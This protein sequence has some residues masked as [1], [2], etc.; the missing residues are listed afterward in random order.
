MIKSIKL[1]VVS[2]TTALALTAT[3]V[4]VAEEK[5][6]APAVKVQSK[7]AELTAANMKLTELNEKLEE[8]KQLLKEVKAADEGSNLEAAQAKLD[9]AESDL[10]AAR[11]AMYSYLDQLERV[12]ADKSKLEEYRYNTRAKT[13][14]LNEAMKEVSAAETQFQQMR[15]KL[16]DAEFF[17]NVAAGEKRAIEEHREKIAEYSK[18]IEET[19]ASIE[20]IKVTIQEAEKESDALSKAPES[21]KATNSEQNDQQMDDEKPGDSKI[22]SIIAAVL[23][24]LG[25]AGLA[26][27]FIP[28][29]MKFFN[30]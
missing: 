30:R 23:G 22:F 17:K 10:M 28:M 6:D 3:G 19:E 26:A 1:A 27:R 12:H 5:V 18:L 13:R 15:Q 25:L 20:K 21:H 29:I 14:K 7:N 2:A 11:H 8:T 24:A 9:K 4:A 16:S